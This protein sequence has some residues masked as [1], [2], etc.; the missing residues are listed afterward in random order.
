MVHLIA[1]VIIQGVM[2][3]LTAL[4]KVMRPTAVSKARNTFH[5]SL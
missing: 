5:F 3:F 1:I 4:T 2:V